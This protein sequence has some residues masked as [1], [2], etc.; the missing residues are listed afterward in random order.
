M[1]YFGQNRG[2][3]K[4]ILGPCPCTECRA[5]LWWAER[6]T[7]Y[8]G[9]TGTRRAWRDTNGLMHD[10]GPKPLGK[11]AAYYRA[12]RARKKAERGSPYRRS[13][14]LSIWNEGLT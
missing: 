10:C 12:Y 1:N 13:A 9:I 8:A 14:A 4:P 5:P 7:R 2:E 6:N 11:D 3:R